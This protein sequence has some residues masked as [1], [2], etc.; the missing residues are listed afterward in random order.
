MT[1]TIQGDHIQGVVWCSKAKSIHQYVQNCLSWA[2][3]LG[4]EVSKI[5]SPDTP[6]A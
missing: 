5:C 6:G 2:V 1:K 4:V 3:E